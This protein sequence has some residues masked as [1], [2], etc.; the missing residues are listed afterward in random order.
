MSMTQ[1]FPFSFAPSPHPA[2]RWPLVLALSLGLGACSTVS[3]PEQALALSLPAQWGQGA[4][5]GTPAAV[6]RAPASPPSDAGQA[7]VAAPAPAA[8]A[9]APSAVVSAPPAA[10]VD[11][12]WTAFGDARLDAL[13]S[14]ALARNTDL[15]VAALKLRSAQLQSQ[16]TQRNQVPGVSAGLSSQSQRSLDGAGSS[17]SALTRS[18]SANLSA[19]YEVDLWGRLARLREASAWEAQATEQDRQSTLLSLTGTVVRQYWQIAYLNQRIRSAAQSVAYAER[20]RELVAAQY[21]AGAVSALETSEAERSVLTQ[22]ATLSDLEQQ[23]LEARTTLALLFDAAPGDATLAQ[24]L[25]QEPAQLPNQA[26]PAVAPELPAQVLARRPDLRAAE[27]RLRETLASANATAASY[28]PPLTLTGALG[29][30]SA[31][32]GSVLANPYALLGAGITLPFLQFNTQRLNNAIARTQYESAVLSY[33]QTLYTALGE[34]ENVL[35]ARQSLARQG[36]S[37][38]GALLAS[39]RS[40]QLYEVRYRQGAVALSLWL[41]AQEAR[42]AAEVAWAQN[43]WLQLRN[44]VS[45]CL[46]LGGSAS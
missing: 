44:Q 36:E 31:A 8:P 18:Q 45:L 39:Q 5:L 9:G 6:L 19:S 7:S 13:V 21:R 17:G 41:D 37:L 35:S 38:A 32:L 1:L 23:R 40:E 30:S 4:P 15:A 20:T 46:A 28:Y 14:S 2:H 26:M 27:M 12:W 24:L 42:R 22:R 16:L 33:R 29:S 10:T 25:P 43:Q 34:V 3:L 11:A